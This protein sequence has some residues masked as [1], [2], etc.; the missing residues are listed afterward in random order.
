MLTEIP[1]LYE[2]Y[3]KD[4]LSGKV[5]IIQT[6]FGNN[7]V[8]S[9]RLKRSL[10]SPLFAFFYGKDVVV[11]AKKYPRIYKYCVEYLDEAFV[12]SKF[13]KNKGSN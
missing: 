6:H 3:V 12:T 8:Y 9:I 2:F 5:N 10:K 1:S 13:L 11:L 4:S 7:I